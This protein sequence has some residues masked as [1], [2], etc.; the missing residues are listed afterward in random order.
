MEQK[1][2]YGMLF[3]ILLI[4]ILVSIYLYKNKY[5]HFDSIINF[6][7]SNKIQTHST[8]QFLTYLKNPG[9]FE[10]AGLH[11][12]NRAKTTFQTTQA[13]ISNG[14][15]P[16][17]INGEYLQFYGTGYD[18]KFYLGQ[19]NPN[20]KIVIYNILQK[21]IKLDSK[22]MINKHNGIYFK[23]TAENIDTIHV[24]NIV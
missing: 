10:R 1:F 12:S 2:I 3:A 6:T 11:Y 16:L 14:S 24:M 7:L 19:I 20:Y 22:Y 8:P 5:E 4:I 18:I 13:D 23:S 9:S 21:T 15:F 17:M